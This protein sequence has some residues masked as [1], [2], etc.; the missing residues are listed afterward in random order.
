MACRKPT[1]ST[2]V[3]LKNYSAKYKKLKFSK[4]LLP[5]KDNVSIC[6]KFIDP[7]LNNKKLPRNRL[8]IKN[9]V[10]LHLGAIKI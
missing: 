9:V 8:F 4:S 10:Q 2:V 7:E 5:I 1:F 6:Y 3:F